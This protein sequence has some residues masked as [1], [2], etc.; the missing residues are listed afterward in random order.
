MLKKYMIFLAVI[1]ILFIAPISAENNITIDN[2]T[3]IQD[4]IDVASDDDIVYLNPGT[5]HESSIRI[6]KNITLQGLGETK[7]IVIDGGQ[8]NSIIFIDKKVTVK[9]NNITF[10]N[11]KTN[12]YGGAIYTEAAESVYIKNCIFENNSAR[13]DGGA[14]EISSKS[15][16]YPRKFFYGYLEI[17]NCSFINNY[18]GFSGGAV[19]TYY[20]NAD[21][22]N[23]EF[24]NNYAGDFAGALSFVN[25]NFTVSSSKFENNYADYDGGAIRQ[26]VNSNLYI[27]DSIFINNTA[28]EWGGAL[29]NW[30]GKLTVKNSTISN[31]TA[32]IRGG[33]I[34]TAGPLTTTYSQIT[35]NSAESG[36]ALYVFQE[37]F[38]IEPI[39]IC[40]YN[41][42][43]GNT[44]SEGSITYYDLLTYVKSDY[45]NNYWGDINPN[46]TKWFEEFITKIFT[47]P[48]PKTWLEE[49][50]QYI[51]ENKTYNND[52]NS[53]KTTSINQDSNDKNRVKVSHNQDSN[54]KN[55][56]KKVSF[57][58]NSTNDKPVDNLK[59]GNSAN[60]I[61]GYGLDSKSASYLNKKSMGINQINSNN[62]PI[63]VF[64][65]LLVLFAYGIY[66][67]KNK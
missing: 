47:E 37:F 59:V 36:G 35:N 8:K 10:I 23:S 53:E 11:G 43:T 25:G 6:T 24:I 2:T 12:D 14:I 50:P 51:V 7:D 60:S 4:T 13:M 18:A 32:G 19:G 46:S 64:I 38:T 41:S 33:G 63:L 3:F 49:P 22:K 45:E 65:M 57:N 17:D 15:F 39:V 5:Y 56:I 9:L 16:G 34:F 20:A 55:H 52:T 30:L 31:N 28:K 66:R 40:N 48:A 67:F 62:N 61:G 42:I 44:A 58:Q 1:L 21:V 26:N 27:E 29:Y 54:D